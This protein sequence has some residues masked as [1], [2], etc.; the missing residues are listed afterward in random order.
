MIMICSN[1]H[2]LRWF[3]DDRLNQRWGGKPDTPEGTYHSVA[4]AFTGDPLKIVLLQETES[5]RILIAEPK[6][7]NM[8]AY[9]SLEATYAQGKIGSW[10]LSNFP[11]FVS[12][13]AEQIRLAALEFVREYKPIGYNDE[14]FQI[15][16]ATARGFHT[17]AWSKYDLQPCQVKTAI[18]YARRTNDGCKN[19]EHFVTRLNNIFERIKNIERLYLSAPTDSLAKSMIDS[20]LVETGQKTQMQLDAE[21][22]LEGLDFD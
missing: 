13:Y 19:V 3:Y 6:W 2:D 8:L 20:V 9:M 4:G 17:I 14:I 21:Y 10:I 12:P 7:T 11:D 1:E 5:K 18:D 22:F 16:H 15:N